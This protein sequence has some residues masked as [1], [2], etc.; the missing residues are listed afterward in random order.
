MFHGNS[1]MSSR[2]CLYSNCCWENTLLWPELQGNSDPFIVAHSKCQVNLINTSYKWCKRG[3]TS[4]TTVI[5]VSHSF[6]SVSGVKKYRW[7]D[8]IKNCFHLF[9]FSSL[10]TKWNVLNWKGGVPPNSPANTSS[11]KFW[12]RASLERCWN[13]WNGRPVRSWLS[14]CLKS[15]ITIPRMRWEPLLIL[16]STVVKHILQSKLH[17]L[18]A[19]NCKKNNHAKLACVSRSPC[20]ERSSA[21]TLIDTTLSSTSTVLRP[22]LEGRLC[23]SCWIWACMT[24]W[25][26]QILPLCFWVTSEPSSNR[27]DQHRRMESKAL[28]TLF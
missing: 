4:S 13:V 8:N 25:R 14:R 18:V 9:C 7:I 12:E 22:V 2:W 15:W 5:Q 3:E 17:S 20:W 10:R 6:S 21:T 26:R 1:E 19:T 28:N 27:S 23:L 16:M 24:T 11:W